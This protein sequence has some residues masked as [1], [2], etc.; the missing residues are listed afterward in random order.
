MLSQELR[1]KTFDEVAGQ[2]ENISILKAIT[3]NPDKSP[4]VLIFHGFFGVGK[5]T[6]SRIFAMELNH[7]KDRNIDILN[8][9][10]YYEFDSTVIGNIDEIKRLRETFSFSSDLYWRVIVLDECH[11]ISNVAQNALLKMLE[12]VQGKT[13]F[14]L[15]TTEVKKLLP[16]IRSRALELHFEPIPIESIVDNLKKVTEKKGI[17]ITDKI[18]LLIAD[19]SDGHMR[20]AHML[21]DKYLLLGEQD[22]LDSVQSAISLYCDYFISI[23][24]NDRERILK[25]IN[26]LMDIPKDNLQNDWNVVMTES[27]RGF[28][29]FP[30]KHIDID[31][32]V[33]TY[34]QDFKLLSN[35]YISAWSKNAFID[36]AN[37]QATFL[38][39][40]VLLKGV[41]NKKRMNTGA[42]NMNSVGNK[43]NTGN[44]SNMNNMGSIGNMG[45]FGKPVR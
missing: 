7:V 2:K 29:G 3:R 6:L 15:A 22:F 45:R 14:I 11:A 35:I 10:Y 39:M 44:T 5:T 38:Y 27:M 43:G 13:F 12:E 23:Y 42:V 20:N 18:A 19:R 28:C 21:L 30:I 40:Y 32:L 1:P 8:T 26:D 31:R 16:T 25:D 34:K 41:L 17:K 9:P 37:F 33:K 36:M 24:N 4:K